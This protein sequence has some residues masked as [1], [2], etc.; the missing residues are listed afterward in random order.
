[1]LSFRNIVIF[2]PQDEGGSRKDQERETTIS[3]FPIE[4]GIEEEIKTQSSTEE[5][6][7][8]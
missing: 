6:K 4:E 1:M 2:H 8:M 5:R 3:F 7:V